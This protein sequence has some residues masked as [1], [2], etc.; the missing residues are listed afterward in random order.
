MNILEALEVAL[1]DLPAQ[2]AQRRF[3]KLDPRV[4]SREH[5]EQ[6][7]RVVLAKMPGTDIYL[8]FTPE[9]WQLLQLFD[10]ERSYKEIADLIFS[11]SNIAFTEE[12][13]R[14]FA[15]YLQETGDL[16]YKT[17]LEKNITLKGKMGTERQKRGRFHVADVTD[18][19]LHTWPN[20]DAYLSKIQPYLEFVYTTWF[21][22]LTLFMFGVMV[23]MWADKFVQIWDD[24]FAFYNFTSKTTQDLVEFWFL[25]GAMAF[26]HESAHGLTCKHFGARVEKMQ[27]LL[28]YFAP[29]FVCDAT[30]VWIVGD[31]KARIST[32]IAG[33]WADLMICVVAT[34]IWW[35]TATGMYI[36]DFAYKVMMVTGIGV[37]LLNL[38]PLIKL[39]G[40][41]LLAELIN[42]ADLKE[43]STIFVSSWTR[44]HIFRLPAEVDYVPRHRRV[45]YIVYSLLSGV[46]SYLLMAV[47]VIFVYHILRSYTPEWAWLPALLL[48]LRIFRS[49]IVMLER[50]MKTV[51]LDKK[52][53]VLAWFTPTR[54]VS[55]WS[56]AAGGAV[57]SH[58][59]GVYRGPFRTRTGAPDFDSYRS[60]GNCC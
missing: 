1:P 51:Y 11:E 49:R 15:S 35:G 40:Y 22:L 6:G 19:T 36:H 29:T 41:Y 3:P 5:I 28:M 33:I 56:R 38:N 43:R 55:G 50:F 45:L 57:R 16:F 34:F 39:D 14:E 60:A 54:L 17:P 44:K 46:Y 7:V 58:L 9:Q 26:F 18:I 53:R 37:T 2:T 31:K 20:A 25:F 8:R 24:S 42:E 32:I 13:V 59:A 48:G 21:T 52:E 47:V 10:G 12:D 30:Q 27:F 23:W 4:I